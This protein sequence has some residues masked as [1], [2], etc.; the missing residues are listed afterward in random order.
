[1]TVRDSAA[2]L[3][4]DKGERWKENGNSQDNITRGAR[5]KEGIPMPAIVPPVRYAVK[6]RLL[7]HLR[8]CQQAGLRLRYLIVINLLTGRGARP[9][10]KALGLHNTTVYR[11][12]KRFRAQGEAGL[13]DGREDN[14]E[15]KLDERYLDILYRVVRSSPKK[16]GWRR[17][18]WTR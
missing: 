12:A 10:A 15:L 2:R 17:P 5:P 13:L 3:L 7:R 4:L 11:V 6:Q 16:H 8:H 14:G 9:T 1:M 18:T